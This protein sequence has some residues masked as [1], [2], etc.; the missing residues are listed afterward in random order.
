[1]LQQLWQEIQVYD[2][3]HYCKRY[4]PSLGA[5]ISS[6]SCSLV[7]LAACGHEWGEGAK[8]TAPLQYITRGNKSPW[9]KVYSHIRQMLNTGI[10]WHLF[11]LKENKTIII[12]LGRQHKRLVRMR[13]ERTGNMGGANPRAD[14]EYPPGTYIVKSQL[15]GNHREL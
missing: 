14:L 6:I 15:C 3:C 13:T 1:M 9:C 10:H 5:G 12:T 4:V 7:P 2:S 11:T 8:P